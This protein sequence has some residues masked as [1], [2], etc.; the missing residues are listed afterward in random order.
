VR[1]CETAGPRR[2][3]ILPPHRRERHSDLC[4]PGALGGTRTPNLLIRRAGGT[5]LGCPWA[6]VSWPAIGWGRCLVRHSRPSLLSIAAVS[7]CSICTRI[8]R[9]SCSPFP[10]TGRSARRAGRVRGAQRASRSHGGVWGRGPRTVPPL[11]RP[12]RRG[13]SPAEG[14]ANPIPR[15]SA[16]D[17]WPAG[18]PWRRSRARLGVSQARLVRV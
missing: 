13:R 2:G 16:P 11:M 7:C 8:A 10:R 6:S 14:T 1:N 17:L 18:G 9:P 12:A 15:S 3:Q 5:V 4:L